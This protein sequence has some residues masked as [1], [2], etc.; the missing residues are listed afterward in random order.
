MA[1]EQ[2]RGPWVPVLPAAS[3]ELAEKVEAALDE[4]AAAL[5]PEAGAGAET[6]GAAPPPARTRDT[7][8][9][10][11]PA[12]R[13]L[14]FHYLDQARPGRGYDEMALAHLEKAIAATAELA[15]SPGLYGGFSGVAWALEHLTGRLLEAPAEGDEDPGEEVARAIGDFLRRTP[16]QDEYDLIGGLVGFGV[17]AIERT[18]RP[19]GRE[20]A[21]DVVRRLAE[22]AERHDGG[23]I[24]WRTPADRLLPSEA[25]TYPDGYVNLGVAHGVPGVIGLLGALKARG[26]SGREGDEL[27]EG[28]VRWLL[29]NSLPPDKK[30]RYGYNVAAGV[31][32]TPA[33]LAWCYGDP[34][35]AA[36]L[37]LAARAAGNREWERAALETARCAAARPRGEGGVMDCGLCHGSAGLMTL[38][39]RLYQATRD[40]LWRDETLHWLEH[41]F[42]LQQPGDGVAGWRAWR[43]LNEVF[44]PVNPELGWTSDP[45]FLTGAAGVG[46]T[47]LAAATPIEPAW[48]LVLLADIPPAPAPSA[49]A[50]SPARSSR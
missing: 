44:D 36:T 27:L 35:I 50:A 33:R 32:P 7:S 41:L 4:I 2:T 31:D 45:G 38:F 5:A 47:L 39:N 9:A 22:T 21:A 46:L 42:T 16:W 18:P 25:E 15:T 3:G 29:A 12:G 8:L 26:M 1:V 6:A 17:W 11:G 49:A 28:A 23:A 40:P 20:A 24:A 48:D 14:F 43:P 34:G 10:D 37:L 13:A 30:S 19:G